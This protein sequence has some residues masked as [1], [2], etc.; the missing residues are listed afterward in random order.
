MA[1]QDDDED[2]HPA[3]RDFCDVLLKLDFPSRYYA[4][5]E[6]HAKKDPPDIPVALQTRALDE[7]G[8]TFRYDK[9]EKFFGWRDS[10]APK[11]CE[12]GINLVLQF[13]QADWILVFGTPSGHLAGSFS[14]IALDA[15]RLADPS[16]QH[17]PRYPT[18]KIANAR[19]LRV[20]LAEGF[21]LYEDVAKALR[22]KEWK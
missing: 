13:A 3:H 6:A 22:S 2:R 18:P 9:K 15:K 21:A 7:T 12:L 8:R 20:V 10:N 11:G 17:D 19:E 14:G 5:C 16:Y 4:Y 1:L